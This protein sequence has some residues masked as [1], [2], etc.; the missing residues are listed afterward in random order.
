MTSRGVRVL[1]I[2][3]NAD[4]RDLMQVILEGAGYTVITAADGLLAMK[5]QRQDPAAVV[6]TDL[7]MPNQDGIETI[8]H[9]RREFPETHIIALSGGIAFG[10]RRNNVDDY[11]STAVLAGADR[12]LTKPFRKEELLDAVE[13]VCRE[14]PDGSPT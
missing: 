11:L 5:L 7:F 9:L 6:V 10:G 12:I 2:D 13:D 3:D 14:H 1:V 8:G 4:L